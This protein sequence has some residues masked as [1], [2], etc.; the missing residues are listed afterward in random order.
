VTL[1]GRWLLDSESGGVTEDSSGHG[2]HGTLMPTY[3]TDCPAIVAGRSGALHA[4]SF[5]RSNDYID[6][7]TG[8]V[9]ASQTLS[10][11]AWIRDIVP[12]YRQTIYSGGD[13][14]ALLCGFSFSRSASDI[15]LQGLELTMPGVYMALSEPNI[16]LAGVNAPWQFVG[17]TRKGQAT[18][19]VTF[20]VNG[21]P[22]GISFDGN[23]GQT[24]VANQTVSAKI[25]QR[26][27]GLYWGGEVQRLYRSTMSISRCGRI[28]RFGR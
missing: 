26:S 17:V 8:P 13:S 18:G 25:G 2:N 6:L 15:N 1:V 20:Y 11:F 4:M 7:G 19:D 12:W 14:S 22:V 23:G 28:G 10:V 27:S 3:P 5:D 21:A 24:I 9:F 16:I